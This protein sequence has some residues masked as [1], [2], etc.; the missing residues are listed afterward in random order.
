MAEKKQEQAIVKASAS[1]FA[2]LADPVLALEMAEGLGS[3]QVGIGDITRLK[4]PSGGS[5]MWTVPTIDGEIGSKELNIII[6][7]VKAGEKAWWLEQDPSGTRPA[8]ISHD[9]VFGFGNNTLDPKAGTG[10]HECASCHWGE[11]GSDRKTGS[12]KDCK[13]MAIMF[14]L[15]ESGAMPRIMHIPPTSLRALTRFRM[16]LLDGQVTKPYAVRTKVTLD[17][18]KSAGGVPYAVMNF[19]VAGRLSQ[20]E[21]A[22]LEPMAKACATLLPQAQQNLTAE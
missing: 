2:L 7:L 15:I 9:G 8:C 12:G 10:Q 16:V 1:S 5:T 11:F 21:V 19:T 22:T 17:A 20:E 18:S 3:S 4:V 13:D 14:F 6:L